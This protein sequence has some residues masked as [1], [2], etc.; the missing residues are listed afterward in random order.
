MLMTSSD[1][2]NPWDWDEERAVTV[3]L[4]Q[5]DLEPLARYIEAHG[6][7]PPPLANYI[8]GL[9][10]GSADEYR[11]RLK[12]VRHPDFKGRRDSWFDD[13]VVEHESMQIARFVVANG[14][15]EAG[16]V[17]AAVLVAMNHF[18]LGRSRIFQHANAKRM[19]QARAERR[20]RFPKK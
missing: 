10:V 13:A 19:K 3:A 5:Y 1:Q 20:Q 17:E 14:G 16:G 6:S 11:T 12:I 8:R 7:I 18:G 2:V 4:E 15:D 9:I